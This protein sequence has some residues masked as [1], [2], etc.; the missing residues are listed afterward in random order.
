MRFFK[1]ILVVFIFFSFGYAKRGAG[2]YLGV[3]YGKSKFYANSYYDFKDDTS[4]I[5]TIYGGAYINKYLS[6]EL[7]YYKPGSYTTKAN[8]EV[9]YTITDISTLAH[10]PFY[11]D[12]FD[13]YG[14]FG[15]GIISTSKSGFDFVFGAGVSYRY[16][17]IFSFKI[18]YD[19]FDFGLDVNGDGSSDYKF[20]IG[21]LYGGFEVQF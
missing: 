3:G 19:Y 12:K 4:N 13:I 20:K 14:K 7:N 5:L 11:H 1:V 6:V 9:K 10:Y 17:E 2:P 16:N 15:A 21:S 8:K 18:G